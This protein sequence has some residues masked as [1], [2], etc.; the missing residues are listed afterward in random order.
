MKSTTF[1]GAIAL[2]VLLTAGA[3]VA[4]QQTAAP[5]PP[6][7]QPQLKISSPAY[8][9][10]G[11]VPRPFACENSQNF[12]HH[13]MA[14]EWS[15]APEGTASFAIVF[16]D[17]DAHPRKGADD[18]LHWMVWNIPGAATKLAENLPATPEQ[19]DGTRQ[20]KNITNT[21]G[22]LGP[23]APAG[24]PHHYILELYALD[25]KLEAGPDSTRADV[26]KAMDGHVLASSVLAG[27]FNQ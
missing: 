7:P 11:K 14:L 9:D 19:A 10:G 27:Q 23:C 2:A 13:S 3:A 15:G 21:L 16:H 8:P 5:K 4:Q 1:A 6:A 17:A 18:V 25:Q 26:V 24:K 12:S 22:Y 20:S